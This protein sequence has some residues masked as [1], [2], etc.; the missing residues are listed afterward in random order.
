MSRPGCCLMY[1]GSRFWLCS[2]QQKELDFLKD[3]VYSFE[4]GLKGLRQLSIDCFNKRPI[5]FRHI[6][7]SH[8]LLRHIENTWGKVWKI[9]TFRERLRY[10]HCRGFPA[11]WVVQRFFEVRLR[12][13]FDDNGWIFQRSSRVTEF[14][15]EVMIIYATRDLFRVSH[16][17]HQIGSWSFRARVAF[18]FI[19]PHLR[20]VRRWIYSYQKLLLEELG[21]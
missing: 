1:Y 20:L 15:V 4:G 19:V 17:G 8:L 21:L 13:S 12:D 16:H 5:Q 9:L 2:L 14:C 10:V 18:I 6:Y 3:I 11:C 7:E